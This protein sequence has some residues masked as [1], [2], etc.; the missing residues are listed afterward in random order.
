MFN[1][2]TYTNFMYYVVFYRECSAVSAIL[3]ILLSLQQ[4]ETISANLSVI[5]PALLTPTKITAK[6][7]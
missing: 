2:L 7:K 1:S 6:F 3:N 5:S 4:N